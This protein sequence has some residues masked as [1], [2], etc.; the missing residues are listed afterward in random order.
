[1]SI[2][3]CNILF[4][5]KFKTFIKKMK[6]KFIN[7]LEE[8]ALFDIRMARLAEIQE[9]YRRYF[10]NHKDELTLT[11]K[12]IRHQEYFAVLVSLIIR[13]IDK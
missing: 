10:D 12:T 9:I 1:M 13:H 5:D 7:Y 8:S 3:V 4:D 6:D 2:N 11:N